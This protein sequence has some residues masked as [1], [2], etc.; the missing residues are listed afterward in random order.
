MRVQST[1]THR[2]F[3]NYHISYGVKFS[4]TLLAAS[5]FAA[6]ETNA[7]TINLPGQSPAE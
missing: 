5:L 2:N 6:L 7:A 3:H 4:L 1:Y